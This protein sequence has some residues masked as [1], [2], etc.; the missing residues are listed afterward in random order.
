MC[1]ESKQKEKNS[2]SQTQRFTISNRIKDKNV[3]NLI[4]TFFCKKKRS[5]YMY[6]YS[7]RERGDPGI[8]LHTEPSLNTLLEKK[9]FNDNLQV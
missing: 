2:Y 8:A 3:E 4:P 7:E 5:Y 6:N 9:P 1:K